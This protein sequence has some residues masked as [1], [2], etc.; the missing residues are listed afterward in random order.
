M[1]QE[2]RTVKNNN[3]KRI[4][5]QKII[6]LHGKCTAL[7]QTV[8]AIKVPVRNM[9]VQKPELIPEKHHI[10]FRL[11]CALLFIDQRPLV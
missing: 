1:F 8:H 3:E 10:Q 4:G 7:A 2:G 9:K 5:C 6:K 11:P